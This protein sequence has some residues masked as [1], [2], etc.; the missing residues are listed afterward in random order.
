MSV[1]D[2]AAS[3]PS[4]VKGET[5]KQKLFSVIIP[6]Y[7]CGR[8]L[9]STVESVLS[10]PGDLYEIIVVDGGS[11]DETLRVAEGYGKDVQV[12]SEADK[13]VYEAYNKGI[14]MSSGKYL[15]FLGAGDRLREGVLR[16]VAALLPEGELSFVYGD[17]YLMRQGVRH[18]G[19]FE[20]NHFVN[21][22]ICHQAIFY[23]RTIFGLLGDY[24]LKYRIYAD[25]VFNLKCFADARVRKQHLDLVVADFEGGG[26]SETQVDHIF[27]RDLPG[28]LWEY[29]G[30]RE[31][32]RYQIYLFRVRFYI[33]RHRLAGSL[34]RTKATQRGEEGK[35]NMRG[36]SSPSA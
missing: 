15:I 25:W 11:T 1:V 28:L 27:K 22:N 24:D 9:A 29:V 6:T 2:G 17:A 36:R 4:G 34:R 10:Q 20:K 16:Q 7:N 12:F 13:G 5:V 19:V 14:G 30:V 21:N 18:G 33:F 26:I 3:I 8:K 32:L 35:L 31:F 23:E